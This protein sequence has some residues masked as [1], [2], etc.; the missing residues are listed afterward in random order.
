MSGDRDP[1]GGTGASHLGDL[2]SALA[3][4]QL[5]AVEQ[6]AAQTHVAT[7]PACAGELAATERM[8]SLVRGL[9]AVEPRRPLVAVP[10]V[11][12]TSRWAGV[13][14]VAAAVVS[15]VALSGVEQD[16][17]ATPQ[18]ASLVQVHATSPVNAEPMSQL[19]PAAIPVSLG[20]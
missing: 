15:L 17:Q 9:G 6:T 7:C 12:R 19:A 13:A 3:D 10:Q 8:R 2:L 14:A 11:A 20:R 5:S 18:V 16:P 4:G 1:T